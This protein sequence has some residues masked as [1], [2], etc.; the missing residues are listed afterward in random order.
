[1]NDRQYA[2]YQSFVRV[3]AFTKEHG[4]EFTPSSPAGQAIASLTS[5]AS[6]LRPHTDGQSGADASPATAAKEDL[7][8]ALRQ[9]LKDIA[10]TARA[11]EAGASPQPGIA[12]R[13]AL[14]EDRTQRSII[15]HARSVLATLQAETV[16]AAR[17]VAYELPSD[18]VADLQND[19]AAYDAATDTQ[20]EDRLGS[21]EGTAQAR[22]LLR[23]G[24]A[25]IV[26]L[27]ASVLNKYRRQPEVIAAWK[28]A[29]RVDKQQS[30]TPDEP[31]PPADPATAPK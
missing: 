1:M 25:A 18:F 6:Q 28:T 31:S 24:R 7:V 23:E 30:S 20:A 8:E 26:Q 12:S 19:L 29:S 4:T 11:I 27:N 22:Q 5:V 17:F 21:V 10:R 15:A 3:L 13:F 9:D 2:L 16:L 14:P